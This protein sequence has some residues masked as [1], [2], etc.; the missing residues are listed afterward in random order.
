VTVSPLEV[1]IGVTWNGQH[2]WLSENGRMWRAN[3]PSGAKVKGLVYPNRPILAWDS[4]L[5]LPI[6]PERGAGEIYPSSLPL[7]KIKKWY[8]SLDR[9]DWK[10]DIYCLIAKKIDG[11]QVVQ[12]L[13]G[14]E[15][16]ITGEV[17]VKEDTADWLPLAAAID[18]LYAGGIPRGVRINATFADMKFTV[19]DRGSN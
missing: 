2:W 13:L 5:A 16:R 10:D 15:E 9:I 3:L 17:I 7:V 18:R 12:M 8:E 6:D 19:S 1:F 14:T 11:R 4:Q